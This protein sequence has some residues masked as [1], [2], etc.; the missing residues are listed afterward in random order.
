MSFTIDEAF[1]Q[2]YK[3]NLYMLAQQKGSKLRKICREETVTGE[4]AWVERIGIAEAQEIVT[5]H[6]DTPILNTPHT[7]GVLTCVISSG[8]I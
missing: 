2:Q 3:N 4:T 5:R 6:G 7:N 8:A 1:V